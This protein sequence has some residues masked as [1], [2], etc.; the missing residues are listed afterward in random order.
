VSK[1]R[2]QRRAVRIAEATRERER[3]ARRV[4]RRERRR[5]LVR[6]LTP[7]LPDRRTGRLYARRAFAQRLGIGLVAVA[8]IGLI[9]WQVDGLSTQI[10]LTIVVIVAAPA[11][12]VLALGRRSS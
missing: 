2:A 1:E 3:R 5:A 9:W 4:A 8:A 11:V 7:R 6:G 12:V 10:A